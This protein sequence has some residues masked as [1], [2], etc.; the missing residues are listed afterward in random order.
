VFCLAV[1]FSVTGPVG[2]FEWLETRAKHS[3]SLT[4]RTSGGVGS[5]AGYGYAML[6]LE[7]KADSSDILSGQVYMR[8]G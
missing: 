1:F 4:G 3:D 8:Q 2:F 7:S 6:N 5:L